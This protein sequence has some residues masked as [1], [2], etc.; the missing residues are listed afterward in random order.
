MKKM[1][2]FKASPVRTPYCYTS[3]ILSTW[4]WIWTSIKI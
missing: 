1:V 4:C 3:Y 2:T